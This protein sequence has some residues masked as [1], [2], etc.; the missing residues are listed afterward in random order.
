MKMMRMNPTMKRFT[1]SGA[2]GN[3]VPPVRGATNER[4]DREI[5]FF[6]WS[7]SVL[8]VVF[9]FL[10]GG[11]IDFVLGLAVVPFAASVQIALSRMGGTK[12]W[13]WTMAGLYVVY[14]FIWLYLIG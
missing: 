10:I 11:P 8:L 2:S 1:Y 7:L 14:G 5:V 4:A 3:P 9:L 6:I 12:W 13:A